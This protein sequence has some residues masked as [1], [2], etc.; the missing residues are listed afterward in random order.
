MLLF[1]SEPLNAVSVWGMDDGMMII[2]NCD[3]SQSSDDHEMFFPFYSDQLYLS[4]T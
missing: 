2:E 4:I 1:I 3:L